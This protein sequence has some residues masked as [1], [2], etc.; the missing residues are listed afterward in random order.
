MMISCLFKVYMCGPSTG[1]RFVDRGRIIWIVGAFIVMIIRMKIF[2]DRGKSKP[3][4]NF[5][6]WNPDI[7]RHIHYFG[8]FFQQKK[9]TCKAMKPKIP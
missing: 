6:K 1:A 2:L 5:L 8:D 7:I 3:G 4:G 9:I